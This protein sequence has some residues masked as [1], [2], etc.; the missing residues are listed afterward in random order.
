MCSVKSHKISS[1]K[2]DFLH[3]MMNINDFI[4]DDNES[5]IRSSYCSA[6]ILGFRIQTDLGLLNEGQ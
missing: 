6:G 5:I 1:V 2:T 4:D 3:R